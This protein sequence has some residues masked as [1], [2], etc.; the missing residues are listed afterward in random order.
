MPYE[1]VEKAGF[2][3]L[4]LAVGLIVMNTTWKSY[5]SDL[6]DLQW[7]D[8]EDLFPGPKLGGRPRSYDNRGLA[9]AGFYS[10]RTSCAWRALPHDFPPWAG[11]TV[12]TDSSAKT[13]S[14]LRL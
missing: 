5:P 14:I 13:T 10:L 11:Y 7:S 3:A 6:S 2:P 8:I 9:D 12:V 1:R 4:S